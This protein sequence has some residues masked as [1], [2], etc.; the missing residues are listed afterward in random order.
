MPRT[1]RFATRS[2]VWSVFHRS[3]PKPAYMIDLD[4][5]EACQFCKETLILGEVA[6]DIGQDFKATTILRKLAKH[7]EAIGLLI[8]VKED[9]ILGIIRSVTGRDSLTMPLLNRL[10]LDALW[11]A[12]DVYTQPL[13][14][15]RVVSFSI[16]SVDMPHIPY[17]CTAHNF[18]NFISAVHEKHE[19]YCLQAQ[20]RFPILQSLGVHDDEE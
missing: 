17:A 14:R 5:I 16:S 7:T 2:W 4:Y 12:L 3:M 18:F 11:H 19:T 1:E 15:V 6:K 13:L 20:S 8:F 9:D 10:E